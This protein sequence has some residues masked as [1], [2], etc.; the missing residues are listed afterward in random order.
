M[1][2][3]NRFGDKSV[4]EARRSCFHIN[5]PTIHFKSKPTHP[6]FIPHQHTHIS[7]YINTPTIQSTPTPTHPHFCSTQTHP[8]FTPHQHT[9][10]SLYINTSTILSTS[11]HSQVTL[12]KK[13]IHSTST[14]PQLALHQHIPDLTDSSIHPISVLRELRVQK[15]TIHIVLNPA[16][17]SHE[18]QNAMNNHKNQ[19]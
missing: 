7:P 14:H 19:D 3:F 16:S 13:P 17:P 11:T 5:I 15:Y 8:Q 1:K 9:H 18:P 10:N 6:Q 12:H 2:Y 4:P